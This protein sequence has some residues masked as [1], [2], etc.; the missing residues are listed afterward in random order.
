MDAEK[1]YS[2]ALRRGK[3]KAAAHVQSKKEKV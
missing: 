2:A 1:K 3:W